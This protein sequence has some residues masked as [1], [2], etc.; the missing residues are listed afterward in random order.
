MTG[1]S[2]DSL[3][4]GVEQST[5]RPSPTPAAAQKGSIR[6]TPPS[7]VEW[8]DAIGRPQHARRWLRSELAAGRRIMGLGHRVY[9]VRDP[10][11][12]VLEGR[13]PPVRSVNPRASWELETIASVVSNKPAMLAA[14]LNAVRTTFTGSIT[15]ALNMSTYSFVFAL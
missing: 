6:V 15:P 8:L 11:A 1:A 5:L 7:S 14:L 10:R 13:M 9:R 4:V 12:A 3:G 2:E